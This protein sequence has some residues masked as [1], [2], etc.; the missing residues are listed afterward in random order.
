MKP[1][2]KYGGNTEAELLEIWKE[3]C[4]PAIEAGHSFIYGSPQDLENQRIKREIEAEEKA[5]R[6][7]KAPARG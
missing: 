6:Q 7:G 3:H 1:K 2:M 4:L 5:A